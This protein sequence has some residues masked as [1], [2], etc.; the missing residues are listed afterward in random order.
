MGKRKE[1]S[2]PALIA[3]ESFWLPLMKRRRV[4][5]T[6]D[7]VAHT[8]LALKKTSVD[9]DRFGCISPDVSEDEHE[10]ESKP[11]PISLALVKPLPLVCPKIL[12][13]RERGCLLPPLKDLPKGRPMPPA[14]R[15]P[16]LASGQTI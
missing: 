9:Q 13:K 14:P 12:P 1:L 5:G 7:S 15:L 6:Q 16:K 8:L 10:M 3:P 4:D 11:P 2:T